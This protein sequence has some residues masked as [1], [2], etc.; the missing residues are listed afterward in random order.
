[1]E[2]ESTQ[3][4]RPN[5]NCVIFYMKTK[6]AL[7]SPL[8]LY[9]TYKIPGKRGDKQIKHLANFWHCWGSYGYTEVLFQ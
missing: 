4:P 1:M 2:L 8:N 7:L 5:G 6:F 9:T 3:N